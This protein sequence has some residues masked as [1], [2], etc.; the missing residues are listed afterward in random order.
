MEGDGRCRANSRVVI[1]DGKRLCLTEAARALGISASALH[2]RITNR[3]GASDYGEVD[4]RAVGADVPQPPGR[5]PKP[6]LDL[7]FDDPSDERMRREEE[8]IT[9][10]LA[11]AHY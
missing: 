3:T 9:R 5:P 2:F 6:P 7:D 1:L 11:R 10:D 8:E 4:I